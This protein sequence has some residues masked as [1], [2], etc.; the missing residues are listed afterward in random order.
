MV[1]LCA[2]VPTPFIE[3]MMRWY[4]IHSTDDLT[5]VLLSV[6]SM[7]SASRRFEQLKTGQDFI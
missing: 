1:Q 3:F 4:V 6:S 7:T 2:S 5:I